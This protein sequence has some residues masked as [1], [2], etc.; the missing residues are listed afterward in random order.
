[1]PRKVLLDAVERLE[2]LRKVERSVLKTIEL[3]SAGASNVRTLLASPKAKGLIA[4]AIMESTA[5]GFGANA[6][7][8]YSNYSTI[9]HEVDTVAIPILNLTGC[10]T[11]KNQLEC[12]R[13]VDA[14]EL[15]NLPALAK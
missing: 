5:V 1:M 4:G 15:T 7:A 9:Q 6:F 13:A 2:V 10:L 8:G 3:E 14:Y 11:S 12:L